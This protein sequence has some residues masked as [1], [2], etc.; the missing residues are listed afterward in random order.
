M[1]T[2][3]RITQRG[4]VQAAIDWVEDYL[5]FDGDDYQP[6]RD[7]PRLGSQYL[8]IFTLMADAMW[9]T[10]GEIAGE[11]GDPEASISAQLR[12]MRKE[13]FGAHTVERRYCGEGLYEYRLL[14][15]IL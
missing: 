15:N 12:H 5:R 3:F 14:L 4:A 13:R 7:D 1:K 10:L 11:T 2:P 6:P 9:R 8:R